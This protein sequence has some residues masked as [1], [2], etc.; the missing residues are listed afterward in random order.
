MMLKKIPVL[1]E[2]ENYVAFNK[3]AGLLSIPTAQNERNTLIDLVNHPEESPEAHTG[4]NIHQ[5]RLHP[6]HRLDRE[7]SGVILFARG[8]SNQQRMMELFKLRRVTKIYIAF[9]KGWLEQKQATIDNPV[10]DFNRREYLRKGKSPQGPKTAGQPAVTQYQ[11]LAQ[12]EDFS[13]VAVTPLTGRTNQIRIHFKQIGHP[14]LG[15]R[16]YAFRRDFAVDFRRLA[17][18]AFSLSWPD[19]LTGKMIT[20]QSP[21]PEDMTQFLEKH[22]LRL[23][24]RADKINLEKAI[25]GGPRGSV[26]NKKSIVK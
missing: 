4:K 8:K 7:T 6:C 1:Y 18:H 15:E 2:N 14:L 9:V 19:P 5:G 13:V 16:V 20:V 3:P 17:L 22:N 23:Q 24:L 25:Q 10:N 21:L 26:R 11:L 12:T